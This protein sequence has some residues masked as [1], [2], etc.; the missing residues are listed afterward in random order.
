MLLQMRP[1]ELVSAF[2]TALAEA[3]LRVELT[4]IGRTA[5]ELQH[6]SDEG[7]LPFNFAAPRPPQEFVEVASAFARSLEDTVPTMEE[8]WID[9]LAEPALFRLP[10]GWSTRLTAAFD[11][12]SL[13]VYVPSRQ[14]QIDLAMLAYAERSTGLD[15]CA[16]LKPSDIELAHSQLWLREQLDAPDWP[17]AVTQAVA[18]VKAL[19]DSAA[20][21]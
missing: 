21:S 20:R 2:A 19:R 9:F 8:D 7:S 11:S 16:L 3:G 14:D 5:H 17:S 10:S 1:L 13:R 4:A 6:D 15:L 18:T 12:P